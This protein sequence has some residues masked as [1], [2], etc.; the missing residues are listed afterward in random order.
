MPSCRTDSPLSPDITTIVPE[1]W[2]AAIHWVHD[3]TCFERC[4]YVVEWDTFS[5]T[6]E[7]MTIHID[8]L[9]PLQQYK[10]DV[11]A[12]CT[13]GAPSQELRLSTKSTREF[14]TKGISPRTPSAITCQSLLSAIV[15]TCGD[16]N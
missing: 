3:A 11:K 15:H 6:T 7:A 14:K 9:K 4:E 10:V 13:T 1:Y 2:T 16:F 5:A 12:Q 8:R